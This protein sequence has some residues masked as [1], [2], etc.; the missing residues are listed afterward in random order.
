MYK[1]VTGIGDI[2]LLKY[3][4]LESSCLPD[5]FILKLLYLSYYSLFFCDTMY[6]IRLKKSKIQSLYI[7][8]YYKH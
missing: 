6:L 2:T 1:Y 7:D 8:Q 4:F 3:Y 5:A